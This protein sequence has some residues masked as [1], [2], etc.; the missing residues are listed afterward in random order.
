MGCGETSP[1]AKEHG[2]KSA[3]SRADSSRK[4]FILKEF[5]RGNSGYCPLRGEIQVTAH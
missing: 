4:R 1:W 3:N 5:L 2:M